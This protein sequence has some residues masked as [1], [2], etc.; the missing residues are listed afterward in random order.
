MNRDFYIVK[1]EK[2]Y[3]KLISN[4]FEEIK[5]DSR[6]EINHDS[7]FGTCYDTFNM[8]NRKM[9]SINSHIFKYTKEL[10][11][12]VSGLS[13]LMEFNKI[14][15]KELTPYE[16]KKLEKEKFYY[17]NNYEIDLLF[18][19]IRDEDIVVI[20]DIS[21]V[22]LEKTKIIISR[23]QINFIKNN[24]GKTTQVFDYTQI[25]ADKYYKL[26]IDNGKFW[27]HTEMLYKIRK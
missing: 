4:G 14:P 27:W 11:D 24:S 18:N 26:N 23:N 1:N 8:C 12:F 16:K 17:K 5:P 20:K 7:I 3:G 19:P 25:Q 21:Q 13:D 2:L 6:Y 22:D 9:F 10:K 15:N